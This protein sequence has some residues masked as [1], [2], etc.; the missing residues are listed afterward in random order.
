MNIISQYF[1]IFIPSTNE[2]TLIL[3][4]SSN[5][6]SLAHLSPPNRPSPRS[7]LFTVV[8]ALN[9]TIARVPLQ[10]VGRTAFFL[11]RVEVQTLQVDRPGV[12]V[13]RGRVRVP[14]ARHLVYSGGGCRRKVHVPCVQE[15][16]HAHRV[17]MRRTH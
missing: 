1:P 12:H 10:S 13:D 8:V 11:H 7:T 9:L 17:R 4:P 16:H 6:F 14:L 3:I 2:P 15:A 5:P